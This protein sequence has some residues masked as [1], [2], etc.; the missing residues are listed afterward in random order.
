M[1][2]MEGLPSSIAQPDKHER[3]MEDLQ[4][5]VDQRTDDLRRL[6]ARPHGRQSEDAA[7]IVQAGP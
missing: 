7:E 2:S 3:Q 4:Q 5:C 6:G 1:I